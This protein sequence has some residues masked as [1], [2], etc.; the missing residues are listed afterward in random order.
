M[1]PEPTN[2]VED[3][4]PAAP[5]APKKGNLGWLVNLLVGLVIVALL[6]VVGWLGYRGNTLTNELASTKAQVVELQGKYD[7]LKGENTA[8]AAE[9]A[10]TR[11]DI[12][13]TKATIEDTKATQKSTQSDLTEAQNKATVVKNRLEGTSKL[14]DVIT[15]IY[16]TKENDTDIL[17]KVIATGNVKALELFSKFVQSPTTTT[18]EAFTNYLYETIAAD[19]KK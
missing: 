19:L 4:Q 12:E 6:A 10:Q 16:V 1:Q 3:V 8:L 5:S 17:K 9:V 14:M 2:S 15:A 13:Q 7:T 11:T 18:L